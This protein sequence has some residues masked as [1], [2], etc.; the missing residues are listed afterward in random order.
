MI[1]EGIYASPK[2]PATSEI[3]NSSPA[4]LAYRCTFMSETSSKL[5][6]RRRLLFHDRCVVELLNNPRA[7]RPCRTARLF[8]RIVKQASSY[9]LEGRRLVMKYLVPEISLASNSD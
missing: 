3:K 6:T 1:F 2:P 5:V 9:S 7:H 8:V 4:T